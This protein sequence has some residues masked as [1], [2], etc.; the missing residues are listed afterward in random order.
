VRVLSVE[1]TNIRLFNVFLKLNIPAKRRIG[2]YSEFRIRVDTILMHDIDGYDYTVT[3]SD[4]HDR[5]E[6]KL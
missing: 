1:P 5:F 4:L 2:Y 3:V 6:Q